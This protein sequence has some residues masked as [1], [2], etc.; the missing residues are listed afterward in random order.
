MSQQTNARVPF[1]QIGTLAVKVGITDGDASSIM[2]F[3]EKQPE[4]FQ[5]GLQ[6]LAVRKGPHYSLRACCRDAAF[7]SS[8]YNRFQQ[9]ASERRTERNGTCTHFLDLAWVHESHRPHWIE[10]QTMSPV[11]CVN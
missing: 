2:L 5:I 11:V 8:A 4:E 7:L 3:I 6:N 9:P 1:M 10:K